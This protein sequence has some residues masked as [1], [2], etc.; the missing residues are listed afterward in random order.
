V[1][2]CEDV[3]A[4]VHYDAGATADAAVRVLV[5]REYLIDHGDHG[6]QR[7][8]RRPRYSIVVGAVA[9]TERRPGWIIVR[10]AGNERDETAG[11]SA[12]DEGQR[13]QGSY[14]SKG[15]FLPPGGFILSHGTH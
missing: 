5:A 9:G 11:S 8:A 1:L 13:D 7:E 3:A 4:L 10:A 2:V 15:R 6:R 12:R 14:P